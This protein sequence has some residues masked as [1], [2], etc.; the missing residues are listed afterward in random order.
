MFCESRGEKRGW[1]YMFKCQ[2]GLTEGKM[3]TPSWSPLF[4][5]IARIV[6][7]SFREASRPPRILKKRR[8]PTQDS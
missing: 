2:L 7:T 8:S 1:I 5:L 6:P 4:L 3:S